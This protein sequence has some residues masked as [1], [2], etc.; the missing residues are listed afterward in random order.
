MNAGTLYRFINHHAGE[1]A[2]A[3][4]TAQDYRAL[5]A[6]AALCELWAVAD[7]RMP[8]EHA[9]QATLRCMQPSDSV[10]GVARWCIACVLDWDTTDKLWAVVRP[11]LKGKTT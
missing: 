11:F 3:P 4:F 8:V 5:E 1:R 10:V 2:L 7:D 6:F 9:M